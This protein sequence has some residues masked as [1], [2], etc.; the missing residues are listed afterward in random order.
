MNS[1]LIL[2]RPVFFFD[3]AMPSGEPG[4]LSGACALLA[5]TNCIKLGRGALTRAEEEWAPCL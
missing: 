5:G 2:R 3:R 1:I 4:S